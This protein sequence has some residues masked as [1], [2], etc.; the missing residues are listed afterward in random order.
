MLTPAAGTL[1]Q[2]GNIIN[3]HS[4]LRGDGMRSEV[5]SVAFSP[6]GTKIVSGSVDGTIKVWDADTLEV[7]D[8][9]VSVHNGGVSSVSFS[10][11]GT[12]LVSSGYT[13]T[14]KVWDAGRSLPPSLLPAA[15]HARHRRHR[16]SQRGRQR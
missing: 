7:V 5:T 10:P 3:A 16:Y 1:E 15:S 4:L 14:I 2:V 11:D 12:K 9:T 13:G 8:E 6:D